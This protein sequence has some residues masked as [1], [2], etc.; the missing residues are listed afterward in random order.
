MFLYAQNPDRLMLEII[1]PQPPYLIGD[2]LLTNDQEVEI[3]SKV[4]KS[5]YSL[6]WDFFGI[7][8]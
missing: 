2:R 3:I 6:I 8:R 5:L 7:L 4:Y 1:S